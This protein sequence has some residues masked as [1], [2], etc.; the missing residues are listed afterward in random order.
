M[1]ATAQPTRWVWSG[2][3]SWWSLRSG[4]GW[5]SL[6][7]AFGHGP[8]WLLGRSIGGGAGVVGD[9]AWVGQADLAGGGQGRLGLARLLLEETALLGGALDGVVDLD[10]GEDAAGDQVVEVAGRL[11]ELAVALALGRGGQLGALGLERRLAVGVVG[12]RKP[13]DR[14]GVARAPGS[15]SPSGTRPRGVPTSRPWTHR[16]GWPVSGC[17]DGGATT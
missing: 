9:A 8:G 14:A 4:G 13:N 17:R 11:P 1:G 15:R 2:I 7:D 3:T 6:W 16:Y 10:L 12:C 5:S